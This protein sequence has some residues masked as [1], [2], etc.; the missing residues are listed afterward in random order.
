MLITTHQY[1]DK[2]PVP[3]NSKIL[4][5]GTIHPH[6]HEEFKVPFFYGNEISIWKIFS[7]A[8]PGELTDPA[9]LDHITRFLGNR[10]LAISDTIISCKRLSPTALDKDLEIIEDNRKSLLKTLATSEILEVICTSG[11]GKNNAF[12]IFYSQILGLP[13]TTEIRKKREAIVIIP[14]TDKKILV[15]AIYSPAR[16]ALT[17]IANSQGYKAVKQKMSVTQYRV[18]LYRSIFE[19]ERFS[20]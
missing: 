15:R 13:I 20:D 3:P 5:L 2:Y 16:T 6:F 9:N 10:E 18:S 11:F 17:G 8:F 7:E 14:G 12:K 1:L 4:I 19:S